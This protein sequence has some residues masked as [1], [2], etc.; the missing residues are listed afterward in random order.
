MKKLLLLLLIPGT[1]LVVA[2]SNQKVS[3]HET[4]AKK[5]MAKQKVTGL[6]RVATSDVKV[7]IE[8]TIFYA[9]VTGSF[10][11]GFRGLNNYQ[12]TLQLK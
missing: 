9:S 3:T 6:K 1:M 2:C 11:A 12:I 7:A 4:D 8:N 10:E 5:G